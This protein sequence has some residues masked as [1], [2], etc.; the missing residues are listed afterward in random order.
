MTALGQ[1]E[2]NVGLVC[3]VSTD[4]QEGSLTTQLQRMRQLIDYKN[5]AVGERWVEIDTYDMQVVSGKDSL[6]QTFALRS[7]QPLLF[8]TDS[9]GSAW[10]KGAIVSWRSGP[11]D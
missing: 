8:A 3:R 6:L 4:L 2:R 9:W 11:L 7:W 5:S 10:A 1:R